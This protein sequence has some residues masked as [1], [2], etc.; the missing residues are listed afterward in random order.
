MKLKHWHPLAMRK[1]AAELMGQRTLAPTCT[2]TREQAKTKILRRQ[3]SGR[4]SKVVLTR[5]D[6]KSE[7]RTTREYA[8]HEAPAALS[9]QDFEKIVEYKTFIFMTGK[10]DVFLE[11]VVKD[12]RDALLPL[13][14]QPPRVS[15]SVRI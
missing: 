9:A 12:D 5:A 13:P 8:W 3:T 14:P 15:P 1:S 6:G 11:S 10:T 2:S 4:F 7:A